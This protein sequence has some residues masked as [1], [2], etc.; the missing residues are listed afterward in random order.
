MAADFLH[1]H[2]LVPVIVPVADA[3]AGGVTSDVISMANYGRCTFVVITGAIEDTGISNVVTVNSCDDTTPST[4]TAIAFTYRAMQWS[5]SAD[6][7]GAQTAATSSGYNFAS[8][9]TVANT[10]WLVEVDAED[11]SGTDQFVQLAIAETANKTITAGV[12]A[13]LSDPRYPQEV[14]VSAI[15]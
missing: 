8:N 2:H 6:T 15:A 11:L 12:I 14:P 10:V 3:F 5:T 13:I 7:W 4:T 9:N 1:D